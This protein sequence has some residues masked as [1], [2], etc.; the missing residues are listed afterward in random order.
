MS[1]AGAIIFAIIFILLIFG[2]VN[3]NSKREQ[4]NIEIL[5]LH[6]LIIWWSA[7]AE[8]YSS[9]LTIEQS[10]EKIEKPE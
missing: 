7:I 4:K 9:V 10:K 2:K 5:I 6:I 8:F 3:Y 1:I